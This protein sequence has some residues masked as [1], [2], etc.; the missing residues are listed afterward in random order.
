MRQKAAAA[1]RCFKQAH[2]HFGSEAANR[3]HVAETRMSALPP[4]ADMPLL[5]PAKIETRQT[6][7]LGDNLAR[8]T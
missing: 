1:L 7:E 8:R 4:K 2:V 6:A 5:P 3:P